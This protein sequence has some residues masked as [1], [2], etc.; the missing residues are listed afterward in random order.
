M[1]GLASFLLNTSNGMYKEQLRLSCCRENRFRHRYYPAV[2]SDWPHLL[3]S[4]T[5]LSRCGYVR[6][7]M[8]GKV[9]TTIRDLS[10]ESDPPLGNQVGGSLEA[11]GL[12]VTVEC[13]D[14]HLCR[15][16][17]WWQLA[18]DRIY[19]R[20][21]SDTLLAALIVSC[22]MVSP[23]LHPG[24]SGSYLATIITLLT[25]RMRKVTAPGNG[26]NEEASCNI[27][28]KLSQNCLSCSDVNALRYINV[29]QTLS[30]SHILLESE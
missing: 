20:L 28:F 27:V 17:P 21:P 10:D 4:V 8:A 24:T 9:F 15:L 18:A 1:I 25:H 16:S 7:C 19:G 14:G 13:D 6:D 5:C 30:D 12:P 11:S 29:L 22:G 2:S 26:K 23:G 3:T